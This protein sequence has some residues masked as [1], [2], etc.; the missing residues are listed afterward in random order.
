MSGASEPS[1]TGG[2]ASGTRTVTIHEGDVTIMITG[3]SSNF[4][5]RD[6]HTSAVTMLIAGADISGWE[7]QQAERGEGSTE[8]TPGDQF[9]AAVLAAVARLYATEADLPDE[10]RVADLLR[11][12][13]SDLEAKGRLTTLIGG[14]EGG[15]RDPA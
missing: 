7:R 1:G 6:L 10:L 14:E 8:V 11:D 12:M 13:I 15:E 2:A 9:R 3:P 5:A 4:F